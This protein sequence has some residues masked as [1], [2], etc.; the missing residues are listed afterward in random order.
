MCLGDRFWASRKDKWADLFKHGWKH[1]EVVAVGC[2]KPLVATEWTIS[3]LCT[4]MIRNYFSHIVLACF[5]HSSTSHSSTRIVFCSLHVK[6]KQPSYCSH[7]W[8]HIASFPGSPHLG[9][10]KPDI[11]Y[12]VCDIKSR[13]DL[14][15]WGWIKQC[16]HTFISKLLQTSFGINMA[17]VCYLHCCSEWSMFVLAQCW[18]LGQYSMILAHNTQQISQFSYRSVSGAMSDTL[19]I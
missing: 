14:I 15:T 13:H 1:M 5:W 2:R 8:N 3:L 19:I 4:D 6:K 12:H 18:Q 10:E 11:F 9:G 7:H 17:L 16:S